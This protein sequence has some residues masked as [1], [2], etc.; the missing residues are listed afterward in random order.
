[1]S[2]LWITSLAESISALCMQRGSTGSYTSQI[3]PGEPG[4]KLKRLS[5]TDEEGAILAE[6]ADGRIVLEIGTG[7]G[8]STHYLASKANLVITLDIDKWV[9]NTVWPI[10]DRLPNVC[11][12]PD[13]PMT[14]VDMVF[15]D[16][17]HFPASVRA[18]M[19]RAG[20]IL[21]PGGVLVFHDVNTSQVRGVVEHNRKMDRYYH[22][23]HGIGVL[24]L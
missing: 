4:Y 11:C 19:Q 9:Q 1:M 18:D 3:D 2:D 8:V 5:I 15:I 21:N 20:T 14:G 23:M 24:Y 13:F 6:L 22:T 16:G 7:L 10:L 17:C 12:A